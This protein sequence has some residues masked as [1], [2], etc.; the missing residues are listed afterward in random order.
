MPDIIRAIA[1]PDRVAQREAGLPGSVFFT[2][3]GEGRVSALWFVCP[4]GC[5]TVHRLTVGVEHKPRMAGPSWSWNSSAGDPTLAPSV[6]IYSD[7]SC[8]GWH[9]WLRDGY[10]EE[11]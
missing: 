10:W 3:P 1:F 9:G 6:R 11:A 5:G 4:C 8:Q 2:D 7:G